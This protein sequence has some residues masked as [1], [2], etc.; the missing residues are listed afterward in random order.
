MSRIPTKIR[1]SLENLREIDGISPRSAFLAHRK[2]AERGLIYVFKTKVFTYELR[3][4]N[5][6]EGGRVLGA[7]PHY[8]N[9]EQ[10]T[11]L[12]VFG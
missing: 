12:R 1:I 6:W 10:V 3:P 9:E 11:V 2:L 5:D 8:G 4:P 7:K